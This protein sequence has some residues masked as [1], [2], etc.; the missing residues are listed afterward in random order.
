MTGFALAHGS[1]ATRVPAGATA[2][3]VAAGAPIAAVADDST[4]AP[5]S[6]VPSSSPAAPSS[7]AGPGGGSSTI[8]A[9]LIDSTAAPLSSWERVSGASDDALPGSPSADTDVSP[10]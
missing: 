6:G 10:D 1:S 3:V 9:R 8:H 7:S 4:P 2:E 5:P